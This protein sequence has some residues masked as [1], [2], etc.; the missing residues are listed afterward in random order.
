M[1][2][3]KILYFASLREQRGVSSEVIK[4]ECHTALE[5]WKE[6]SRAHHLHMSLDILKVAANEEYVEFNYPLQDGDQI[7]FIPPVAGG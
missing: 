1:K 4:T 7:V 2:Q 5:L 3:I 6:I